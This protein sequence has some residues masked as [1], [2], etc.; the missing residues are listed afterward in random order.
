MTERLEVET[1]VALADADHTKVRK[2][3]RAP[4]LRR[5]GSVRELTLGQTGCV[6]EA[7]AGFFMAM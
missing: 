7:K 3:Y 5:L 6:M 1:S 2:T 4:V